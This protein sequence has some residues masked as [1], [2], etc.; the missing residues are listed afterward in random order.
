MGAHRSARRRKRA[1]PRSPPREP[2]DDD[3]AFDDDDAPFYGVGQV[4]DMLA[5][6]RPARSG[7]GN[8]RYTR[9]AIL[10]VEKV[11]DLAPERMTL[12]GIRRLLVLEDRV[13]HL[14]RQLKD[15]QPEQPSDP[16]AD[17]QRT[18][19]GRLGPGIGASPGSGARAAKKD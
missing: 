8:R 17:I 9:V 12:A 11:P 10:M 5:L 7:G 15:M 18:G 1:L 13:R 3:P 19:R 2:D 6:V 16:T 14:Q 4:T